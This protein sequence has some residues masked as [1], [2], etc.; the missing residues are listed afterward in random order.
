MNA[1]D[2]TNQRFEMLT[3]LYP[4]EARKDNCVQWMCRCDCGTMKIYPSTDLTRH[5]VKS[6]GCLRHKVKDITGERRGHLTALRFTGKRDDYGS[7]IYEWRCD[8]GNRI[9]RSIRGTCR[10]TAL[11]C[12]ECLRGVK[13]MQIN[14]ARDNREVEASTGLTR[15]YLRNILLG[16]LT[17]PN[18]SG[19]RGVYW[20]QG[21][22]RWVATGCEKG[23]RVSL[24]EYEDLSEAREAR[25]RYV[26]ETYG[27]AA[28]RL[29]IEF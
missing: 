19:V 5:R 18:T 21:H 6:C 29:G 17:E 2:L 13:V 27:G 16:V 9:E 26:L 8:C 3:A 22:K 20:H 14:R 4:V 11:L 24:G 28:M 7:A 1:R 15:Q 12:P 23:K 25:K 10:D